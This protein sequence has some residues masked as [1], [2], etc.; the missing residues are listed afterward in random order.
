MKTLDPGPQWPHKALGIAMIG[1]GIWTW[2]SSARDAAR[3]AER[4]NVRH[5]KHTLSVKP[6]IESR[7]QPDAQW[8]AGLNVSW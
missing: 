8:R 3:A 4:A 5:Q 7:N 6:L 2:I 1:T